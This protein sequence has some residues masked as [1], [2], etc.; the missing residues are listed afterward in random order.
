MGPIAL[1]ERLDAVLVESSDEPRE[2]QQREHAERD[3]RVPHELAAVGPAVSCSDIQ[4][5][6]AVECA[7]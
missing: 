7:L 4:L 2:R 6:G 3:E 1:L 5:V